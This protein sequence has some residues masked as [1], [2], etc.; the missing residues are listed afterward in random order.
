MINRINVTDWVPL[1]LPTLQTIILIAED[2]EYSVGDTF[3]IAGW[4]NTTPVRLERVIRKGWSEVEIQ[5]LLHY[6]ATRFKYDWDKVGTHIYHIHGVHP[7][8]LKVDVL[9]VRNIQD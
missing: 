5:D 4:H 7:A 6:Y 3:T 1:D 2:D 8:G 9:Y